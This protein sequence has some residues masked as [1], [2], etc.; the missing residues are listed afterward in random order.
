[1]SHDHADCSAHAAPTEGD[2]VI[3]PVCGM[4]VDPSSTPHHAE[5]DGRT[6]H[7]CSAGCRTKFVGDPERYLNP[8]PREREAVQPGA[9]YTCP[10][11]PEVRQ[12]GPG[13]CPKCGM[14]LEPEDVSAETGP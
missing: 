5:H 2:K 11:H 4:T 10:M 8:S 13:G 9:V 3:D 6:H 14:A 1:M 7:F 12:I